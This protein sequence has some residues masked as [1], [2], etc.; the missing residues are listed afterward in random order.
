MA[1]TKEE[2]QQKKERETAR[3]NLLIESVR[4]NTI[5]YDASLDA[6]K[7]TNKTAPIWTTI[8]QAAGYDGKFIFSR[9]FDIFR[10]RRCQEEM[11]LFTY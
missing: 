3:V 8:S 4:V 7:D 1:L 9:I 11:E 2:K 5:L 6:Y 10:W